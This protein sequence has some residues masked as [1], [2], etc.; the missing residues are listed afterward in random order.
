MVN[1]IGFIHSLVKKMG[2]ILIE[3]DILTIESAINFF[4]EKG[5]E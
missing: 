3:K 2:E 4:R 1:R 5:Y